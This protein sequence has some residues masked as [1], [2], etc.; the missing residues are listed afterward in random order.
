MIKI[1]S[2]T[3]FIE[4]DIDDS[5][6]QEDTYT[7]L[8]R[9]FLSI[10]GP[11]TVNHHET[12]E[13]PF[14]VDNRVRLSPL[15]H[16]CQYWL[17]TDADADEQWTNVM[18]WLDKQLIK[19]E[20]G[21]Q[22]WNKH[23]QERDEYTIDWGHCELELDKTVIAC[24]CYKTGEFGNFFD[25]LPRYRELLNEGCLKGMD[26]AK[27]EM[28]WIDPVA[29]QEAYDAEQE[30]IRLAE[31]AAAAEAEAEAAAALAAE[32]AEAEVPVA[33]EEVASVI[34]EDGSE[35]FEVAEDAVVDEFEIN[36]DDFWAELEEDE[37]FN[38]DFDEEFNDEEIIDYTI[39]EV[40]LR[41][42]THLIVDSVAGEIIPQDE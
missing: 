1:F 17:S 29:L 27:V 16:G 33:E 22:N 34:T 10:F 21:V 38:D 20:D 36:D 35:V 4:F 8:R 41:D 31:E 6:Y 5:V 3:N 26:V 30:A 11:V 12:P 37:E 39:W 25:L 18:G 19:L 2:M 24:K 15:H 9:A 28:P 23:R 13:P 40:I 7:V 32:Q 14:P 42:G